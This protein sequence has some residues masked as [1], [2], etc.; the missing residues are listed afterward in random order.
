MAAQIVHWAMAYGIAGIVVA[1]AFLLWGLDRIDPAAAGAYA[2]RPL[3][4]PGV[5]LLW[6]VVAIRW[7][8]LERRRA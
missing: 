8:V 7:V 3:L 2:F 5:V 4:F 1:L 6:P